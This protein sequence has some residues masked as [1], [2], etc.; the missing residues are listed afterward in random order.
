MKLRVRIISI[1]LVALALAGTYVYARSDRSIFEDYSFFSRNKTTVRLWYTDDSLTPYLQSK[2]VAYSESNSKVRIEPVLVSGLEYLEAVGKASV[3]EDNFPDLYIITNDSLEKAYLAG[4][5]KDIEDDGFLLKGDFPAAALNSVTYKNKKVAYPFYFETSTLIYNKTYLENMATE[6]LQSE[7]DIEEG[8]AAQ[9]EIDSSE[10]SEPS[11]DEEVLA[12]DNSGA[13]ITQ[14]MIDEAVAESLPLNISDILKFA[15]NY[16]APEQVEAVFEWDVTDIFYNYFFVGNYMNVGGDFGDDLEQFDIY[17]TDTISCMKIYQQL[18]QFFAIDPK[19]IDYDTIVQD[20]ID[21]KVVFTIATTDIMK[22]I[23]DAK[24]SGECD[25]EFEVADMPGLTDDFGSRTMSVTECLVVNG[26]SENAEDAEDVARF[27][28]SDNSGDIY[29]LSN[30][31]AAHDG[32]NYEDKRLNTFVSVYA[33]SVPMPKTIETSNLWMELE[34]AFTNIWN[35][36]DCNSTLK[37]VSESIKTQI[38]GTEYTETTIPDPDD[39]AIT[40]GL[41]EDDD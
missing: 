4:L 31:L 30:K 23:E 26:Y 27:L 24:A 38:T 29:K 35:G 8:E 11:E 36:A 12:E 14:G 3:N 41:V 33:D 1:I 17:N 28:C 13:E 2:A 21:G 15:E 6:N 7:I 39:E 34:I 9:A 16:N 40:A 18:N 10:N 32:V 22:K 5:A 37:A 19:Q 20:F 25:F